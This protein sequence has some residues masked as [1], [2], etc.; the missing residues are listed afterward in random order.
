MIVIIWSERIAEGSVPD[1]LGKS[2]YWRERLAVA[3]YYERKASISQLTNTAGQI[4]APT[5]GITHDQRSHIVRD[6]F[7]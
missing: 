7:N 5:P 6:L 2:D 1:W 3:E 4:A